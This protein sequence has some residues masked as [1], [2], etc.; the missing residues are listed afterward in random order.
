MAKTVNVLMLFG[1]RLLHSMNIVGEAEARTV[2]ASDR[3]VYSEPEV[4]ESAGDVFDQESLPL[5]YFLLA[6]LGD[7]GEGEQLPTHSVCTASM[8]QKQRG[9]PNPQHSC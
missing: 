3:R 8:E 7:E 4:G 1:S 2:G 5:M 9:V 6:E